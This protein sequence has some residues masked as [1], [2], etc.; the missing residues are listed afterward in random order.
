MSY[1][2]EHGSNLTKIDMSGMKF[3]SAVDKDVRIESLSALEEL[4]VSK[5]SCAS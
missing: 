5:I 1:F 2:F 4:N 3:T